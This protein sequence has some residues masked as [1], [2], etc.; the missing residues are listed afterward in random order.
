MKEGMDQTKQDVAQN[1][2]W[3]I[4]TIVKDEMK[5]GMNNMK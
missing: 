4:T 1:L 2:K 3:V 5:Q